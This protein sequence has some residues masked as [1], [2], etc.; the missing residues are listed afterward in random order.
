MKR[1]IY[2][3]ALFTLSSLLSS[4]NSWKIGQ[5]VQTTS[6]LVHGHAASNTSV[7]EYLGI[8]YAEPPIGALRFEPPQK[9]T[10]NS[11]INGTNFVGLKTIC[12]QVATNFKSGLLLSSRVYIHSFIICTTASYVQLYHWGNSNS[13]CYRSSR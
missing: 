4:A 6:G 12:S 3:A 2:R 9:Y 8:P 1:E 13:R 7:S 5:S 11:T 10:S